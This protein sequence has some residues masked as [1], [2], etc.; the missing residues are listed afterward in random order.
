MLE[1]LLETWQINNRI[2]LYL[3]EAVAPENLGSTLVSKGRGAGEQFAHIHNVRLMWIKASLP[4]ALEKSAKIE[5]E[6]ALDKA[7]LQKSLEESG[8]MIAELLARAVEENGRVKGFK[9]H[10]TAFL[11]YLTSHEAHHRSQIIIALK[12][13]GNPLDKKIL[14]GIWEWGTR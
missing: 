13:S 1:Q 7:L 14:F 11:A 2:N 6:N 12:Q 9:P 3:L 5:K 10:V 4:E 8:E